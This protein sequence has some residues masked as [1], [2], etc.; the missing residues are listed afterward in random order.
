MVGTMYTQAGEEIVVD[1]IEGISAVHFDGTNGHIEWGLGT[2]DPVKGNTDIETT[3]SEARSNV[4]A[5]Q[6]SADINQWVATITAAGSKTITECAM[7]ND[8][9]AG[10]MLIRATFAGIPVVVSDQI[11]FTISLEQT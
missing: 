11:E 4:A 2:T 1:L 3:T 7:F 8:L 5:S 6:P 10:V 9:T